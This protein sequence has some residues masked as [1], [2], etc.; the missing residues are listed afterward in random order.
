MVQ[1]SAFVDPAMLVEIEAVAVA[2]RRPA[3]VARG[4]GSKKVKRARRR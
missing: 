1:V 4:R 2:P 3:A